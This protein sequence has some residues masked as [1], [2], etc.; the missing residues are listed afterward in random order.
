VSLP[1]ARGYPAGSRRRHGAG[2]AHH[3][4]VPVP[5]PPG[6]GEVITAKAANYR[7]ADFI[8]WVNNYARRHG[9]DA[10]A[11]P[12]AHRM[13]Q[14]TRAA[15][16]RFEGMFLSPRQVRALLTDPALQVHDNPRAQPAGRFRA[17]PPGCQPAPRAALVRSL[18]PSE[19]SSPR[20]GL[21]LEPEPP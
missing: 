3:H 7:I 16:T 12:A 11:I 13:L 8:S 1:A 20:P 17:G 6:R 21:T 2:T 19:D 18:S 10:E 9:L 15:G 4:A 5:A 14:A